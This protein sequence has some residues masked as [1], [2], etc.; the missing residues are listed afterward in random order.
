MEDVT[1]MDN[2]AERYD[3]ITVLSRLEGLEA[4]GVRIGA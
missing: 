1:A 3:L 4:M 2:A